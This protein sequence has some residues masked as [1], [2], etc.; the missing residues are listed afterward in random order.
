MI[1]NLGASLRDGNT[2][3]PKL[4]KHWAQSFPDALAFRE[5]DYGI[6]NRMSWQHYLETARRFAHGLK[7][8]GFEKGDQPVA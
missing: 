7:A 8:L 1:D 4:L 5:K 3:L 6:W 2:T